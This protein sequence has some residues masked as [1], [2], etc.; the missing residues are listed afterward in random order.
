M[1]ETLIETM[2][3]AAVTEPVPQLPATVPLPGGW[4]LHKVAALVRD[5]A[6]NLYDEA[7]TLKKHGL[8]QAQFAILKDNA[9]FKN[10]IEQATNEWNSPQSTTRRLALEA[11]IAVEDALPV[12]AARMSKTN[13]PLS[14][15]VALLKVLSEIAGVTG[16]KAA[17]QQQV[18]GEKFK[19]VI[20]LGADTMQRSTQPMITI[21]Q[22]NENGTPP[23]AGNAGHQ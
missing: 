4:T 6:M 19:I 23:V 2:L 22:D 11:A 9:Y 10:A 20:N 16:S 8:T 5:L 18:T 21:N 13:E 17:A 15:V 7:D 12:V 1:T 14:D 3:T